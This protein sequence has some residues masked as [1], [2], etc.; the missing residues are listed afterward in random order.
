M[1][2][3]SALLQR[4]AY[5]YS[6]RSGVG[7]LDHYRHR[8]KANACWQK[9]YQFLCAGLNRGGDPAVRVLLTPEGQRIVGN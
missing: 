5:E 2:Q 8:R 9:Y 1:R 6:Y 7:G 4:A 3:I